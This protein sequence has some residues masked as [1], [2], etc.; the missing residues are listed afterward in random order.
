[1]VFQLR[2]ARKKELQKENILP[3]VY[4]F[5]ASVIRELQRSK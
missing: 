4:Y 1:M 5:K 2:H 3:D